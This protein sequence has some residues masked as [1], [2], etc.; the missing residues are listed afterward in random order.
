MTTRNRLM[1]LNERHNQIRLVPIISLAHGIHSNAHSNIAKYLT[2]AS[3]SNTTGTGTAKA[4]HDLCLDCRCR[5]RFG[6][7]RGYLHRKAQ[8]QNSKL[9]YF[10]GV[11]SKFRGKCVCVSHDLHMDYL[12]LPIVWERVAILALHDD[13]SHRI[14]DRRGDI[15][16]HDGHPIFDGSRWIDYLR[17]VEMVLS[18]VRARSARISIML[19]TRVR[20]RSNDWFK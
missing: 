7:T 3:R 1:H 17:L 19:L 18:G 20:L 13:S 6:W 15:T 11:S 9:W 4:R 5:R 16:T 14:C 8:V 2:R 12:V 10:C